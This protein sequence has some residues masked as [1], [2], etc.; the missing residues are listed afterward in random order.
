MR[1]QLPVLLAAL[2]VLLLGWVG[3]YLIFLEGGTTKVVV[4]DPEGTVERRLASGRAALLESGDELAPSDVVRVSG[5]GSAVLAIGEGSSLRLGSSTS[6]RLV[7]VGRDSVQV[8]LEG[9]RVQARVRAV[10]PGLRVGAAGRTVGATDA[11]FT[12]GIDPTGT[13]AVQAE[14]GTLT[15]DEVDGVPTLAAGAALIVPR[16]G[17]AV[18]IDTAAA[19]LLEVDWP[20]SPATGAVGM[21]EG[22]T[23][24]YA[25]V[26]VGE[27]EVLAGADGRFQARL[28]L[29][30]GANEVAVTARDALGR[31]QAVSRTILRPGAPPIGTAEVQWAP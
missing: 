18:Q 10:G 5:E 8:E 7:D 15:M 27:W 31:E 12:M 13:L 28:P 11:D 3:W 20:S 9:G 21:V 29:E 14:R 23:A 4:L 30:Q 24:P 16:R 2:A 17:D 26:Q 6:L 25:R 1:K 19:L 22:Q